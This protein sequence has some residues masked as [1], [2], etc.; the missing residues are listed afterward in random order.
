M[1]SVRTNISPD[2]LKSLGN[3]GNNENED[4]LREARV[5]NNNLRKMYEL[6]VSEKDKVHFKY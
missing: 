6:K 2:K 5:D 1:V 4:K 3:R